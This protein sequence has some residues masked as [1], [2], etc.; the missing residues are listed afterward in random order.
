M[1]Q[2]YL[3]SWWQ[4]HLGSIDPFGLQLKQAIKTSLIS[5][6][7]ILL[8]ILLHL[9][10]I[11]ALWPVLACILIA[12]MYRGDTIKQRISTQ[13]IGGIIAAIMVFISALA[14]TIFILYFLIMAIAT[15]ITFYLMKYGN[16][17]FLPAIFI[18]L[19]ILFSGGIPATDFTHAV[20]R[21][22]AVL[23][24]TLWAI[25]ISNILWP[26]A[27]RKL[28]QKSQQKI[29]RDIGKYLKFVIE[30]SARG[31]LQRLR[32]YELKNSA[33]QEIKNCYALTNK[34]GTPK[35][36]QLLKQQ[37]RLFAQIAALSDLFSKPNSE[38]ILDTLE[39]ITPGI[40]NLATHMTTMTRINKEI[41]RTLAEQINSLEKFA[42]ARQDEFLFYSDIKCLSYLLTRLQQTLDN[43]YALPN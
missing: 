42:Q 8:M 29:F 6:A 13:L 11:D 43:I 41:L 39:S 7:S 25:L 5:G 33:L 24:S 20:Y 3:H 9:P 32:R 38:F 23:I 21:L 36:K 19:M 16:N 2:K 27:P 1:L 28:L 30:D 15:L 10:R 37:R 22:L 18:L 26:F 12:Q 34:Y 40:D 35:N 14:G 4:R 31:N 17:I